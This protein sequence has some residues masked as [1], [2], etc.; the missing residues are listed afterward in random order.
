[1]GKK[2][3]LVV[4]RDAD[5]PGGGLDIGE[6]HI[7]FHGKTAKIITDPGLADEIDKTHGLKGS[8][9]VWVERDERLNNHTTYHEDGIHTYFFGS[10]RKFAERYDEIF[11][12]NALRNVEPEKD[13]VEDPIEGVPETDGGK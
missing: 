11:R 6:N 2:N 8:G 13:D 4:S 3:F 1:M 7:N 9:K 10:S 12:K 5:V